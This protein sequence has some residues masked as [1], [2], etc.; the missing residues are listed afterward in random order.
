[1]RKIEIENLRKRIEREAISR[2]LDPAEIDID[3][4]IDPE[5]S[6]SENLNN[7]LRQL[8]LMRK[9]YTLRQIKDLEER[10]QHIKIN[11]ETGEII[12]EESK[13]IDLLPIFRD[14]SEKSTKEIVKEKVIVSFWKDVRQYLKT[15][16]SVCPI[17]SQPYTYIELYKPK[18]S[19]YSGKAPN[20]YIYFVH[21]K[22]EQGNRIRKK[23]Y[24][25]P[26]YEYK[27]A[28]ERNEKFEAPIKQKYGTQTHLIV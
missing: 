28:V 15:K 14:I 10:A 5:L 6:Y 16:Y 3:A 21:Q 7:I 17:C 23:C 4:L 20:V 19:Q 24:F 8:D 11:L 12:D 18:P 9:E 22:I 25:R 27:Y 26:A 13:E 1:M 2:G